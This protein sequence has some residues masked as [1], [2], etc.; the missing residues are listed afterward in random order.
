M[1]MDERNF[2]ERLEFSTHV[3][4][5]KRDSKFLQEIESFI[6]GVVATFSRETK[7]ETRDKLRNRL[8]A[9]I[10]KEDLVAVEKRMA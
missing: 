9:Q 3:P 2:E 8:V 7:D 4:A 10:P 1:R 6:E 5:P